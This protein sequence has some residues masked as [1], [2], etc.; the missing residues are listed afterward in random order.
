LWLVW[1]LKGGEWSIADVNQKMGGA[2]F[3]LV[4]SIPDIVSAEF[5]AEFGAAI[6]AALGIDCPSQGEVLLSSR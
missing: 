3:K 4:T 1:S 2:R 6:V 5:S